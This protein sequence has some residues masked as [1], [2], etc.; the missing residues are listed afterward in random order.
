[1]RENIVILAASNGTCF[2]KQT[3][4]KNIKRRWI[5]GART[6][7]RNENK[8][9]DCLIGQALKL[10]H[11]KAVVVYADIPLNS[12]TN[13]DH[14]FDEK[15]WQSPEQIA[16]SLLQ[17]QQRLEQSGV[18]M[19]TMTGRRPARGDNPEIFLKDAL[20]EKGVRFFRADRAAE[21]KD[22]FQ[23]DGVHV[24]PEVFKKTV[25]SAIDWVEG[26]KDGFKRRKVKG[27]RRGTGVSKD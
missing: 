4:E 15:D 7:S 19:L 2:A 20:Q 23:A 24:L 16:E 11:P 12:L 13:K 17:A 9:L 27:I 26:G 21:T 8:T 18:A 10:D 3:W 1:M 22:S 5:S 25:Q 14:P 6:K